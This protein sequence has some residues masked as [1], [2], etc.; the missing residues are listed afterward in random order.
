MVKSQVFVPLL[1]IE[2]EIN[3]AQTPSN[4]YANESCLPSFP[5]QHLFEQVLLQT[6]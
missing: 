6:E 1:C 4:E 3:P 2:Y 5:N